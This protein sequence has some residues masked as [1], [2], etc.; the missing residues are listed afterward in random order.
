M[1][2]KYLS[3]N[4]D[5]KLHRIRKSNMKEDSFLYCLFLKVLNVRIWPP[6]KLKLQTNSGQ[7]VPKLV[8]SE[9]SGSAGASNDDGITVPR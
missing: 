4:S 7:T 6:V 5:L 8:S 1:I 2:I 3:S 9:D